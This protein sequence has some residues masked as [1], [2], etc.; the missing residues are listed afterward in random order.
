[1]AKGFPKN[2]KLVFLVYFYFKSSPSCEIS[3]P[4]KNSE[5]EMKTFGKNS[6]KRKKKLRSKFS[7]K[8]EKLRF[9]CVCVCVMPMLN[10]EKE[11]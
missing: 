2:H 7:E 11:F 8:V 1:M 4:K 9:L 3:P 6:L 5:T 10:L